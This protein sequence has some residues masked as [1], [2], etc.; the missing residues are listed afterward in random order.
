MDGGNLNLM[1]FTL[2]G[3]HGLQDNPMKKGRIKN[4]QRYVSVVK[5]RKDGLQA[6]LDRQLVIEWKTDY[7]DASLGSNDE[8]HHQNV[9]GLT[10]NQS[11]TIFYS[12]RVLEA[13]GVGKP[14][15]QP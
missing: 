2:I 5:V 11:P 12:V 14:L 13:S 15:T 4:G 10:T 1:G 3:G 8:M 9:L 7:H 6:F